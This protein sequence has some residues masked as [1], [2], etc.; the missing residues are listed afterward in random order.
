MGKIDRLAEIE[1]F[2]SVDEMLNVAVHED[3]VY[4]ICTNKGCDYTMHTEPDCEF[5]YC[6]D[7][8]TNT[9]SSSLVLEGLI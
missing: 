3:L 2:N 7:C 5:G 8:S 4:G 9:I 6:E 1:G